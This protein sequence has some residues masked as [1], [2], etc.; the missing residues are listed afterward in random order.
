MPLVYHRASHIPKPEVSP[1]NRIAGSRGVWP[2]VQAEADLIRTCSMK[3]PR[4]AMPA[5]MIAF[6]SGRCVGCGSSGLSIESEQQRS[7]LGGPATFKRR[8]P[9]RGQYADDQDLHRRFLE[10]ERSGRDTLVRP[11]RRNVH[12]RHGFAFHKFRHSRVHSTWKQQRWRRGVSLGFGDESTAG[13]S[14]STATT[15]VCASELCDAADS[16]EPGE[17]FSTG[18]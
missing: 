5:V 3:V 11:E 4:C 16:P 12:S 10:T 8:Q 1:H 18:T 17:R 6:L 9:G 7:L 14:T 13:T 2:L 15:T